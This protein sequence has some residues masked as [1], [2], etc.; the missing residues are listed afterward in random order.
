M[1]ETPV[2]LWDADQTA[3]FLRLPRLTLYQQRRRG[4]LPGALGFIVGRHLRFDSADVI[5]WVEKQKV[6]HDA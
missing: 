1:A 2:P 4:V 3:E 6:G 5:A